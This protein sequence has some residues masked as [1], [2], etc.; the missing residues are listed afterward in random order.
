M[1]REPL[2][3]VAATDEWEVLSLD[4]TDITGFENAVTF[5]KRYDNIIKIKTKNITSVVAK[6]GKNAKIVP[7]FRAAF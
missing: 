4:E 6:Q 2:N 3:S 1:K 5:I 7:I